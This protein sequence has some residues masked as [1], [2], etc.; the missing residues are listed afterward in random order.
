MVAD[1][2][3]NEVD[4]THATYLDAKVETALAEVEVSIDS[5]VRAAGSDC[6]A[7]VG[8]RLG[9]EDVGLGSGMPFR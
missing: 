3:F 9:R 4:R 8:A 2:G 1:L 5:C 7:A 6:V